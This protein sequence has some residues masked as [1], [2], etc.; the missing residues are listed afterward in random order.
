MQKL[1]PEIQTH[2]AQLGHSCDLTFILNVVI[3]VRLPVPTVLTL[4]AWGQISST[5][6]TYEA[7]IWLDKKKN[8]D[9]YIKSSDTL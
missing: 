5:L 4:K 7:Q 1:H 3:H 8:T 6:A 9:K 2:E